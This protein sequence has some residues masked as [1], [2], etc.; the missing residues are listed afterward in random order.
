MLD[1]GEMFI[2]ANGSCRMMLIDDAV[3][4]PAVILTYVD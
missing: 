1:G 2:Y 4:C 3:Q